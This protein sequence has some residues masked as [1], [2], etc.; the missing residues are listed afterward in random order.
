MANFSGRLALHSQKPEAVAV[1]KLATSPLVLTTFALR[2]CDTGRPLLPSPHRIGEIRQ[3]VSNEIYA[4]ATRVEETPEWP[5]LFGTEPS[6]SAEH[7]GATRVIAL[8]LVSTSAWLSITL[9][10][11]EVSTLSAGYHVGTVGSGWIAAAE[12][13]ALAC[14]APCAINGYIGWHASPSSVT[15]PADQRGSGSRSNSAQIKQVSAAEMMRRICGCQPSNAASAR[16][17]VAW[18]VQ[19]SRFQLSCSVQPTKFSSRPA[20]TK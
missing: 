6:M 17:M 15:R 20:D 16:S 5:I 10:P 11:Y 9:L 14:A 13:L 19:S 12:L 3:N 7:F 2:A 18:S 1:M 4:G 8:A